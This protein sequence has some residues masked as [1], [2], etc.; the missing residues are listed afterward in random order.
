MYQGS[1]V[2][3]KEAVRH[4]FLRKYVTKEDFEGE[5]HRVSIYECDE[6]LPPSRRDATVKKL[7]DIK[8]T[9]DDL[10]Y[11]R[12]ED[13]DG[14]MGKKMKKWSYDI[15]MVPSEA[16]TEFPVYYLGDKVGSQNI[17]LEFQ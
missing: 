6:L 12:L 1:N 7:C 14:W 8:I 15:E 9:M 13:F 17:A 16:S 4:T 10:N 5:D 2:S 11:D 3:R